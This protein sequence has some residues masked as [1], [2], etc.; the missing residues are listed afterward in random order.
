MSFPLKLCLAS[1]LAATVLASAPPRVSR[2]LATS[3]TKDYSSC[4]VVQAVDLPSVASAVVRSEQNTKSGPALSLEPIC[5][6]CASGT[7][8][9]TDASTCAEPSG[10][11]RVPYNT[12]SYFL[13][14]H[15]ENSCAAHPF[16]RHHYEC[17]DYAHGAIYV[18]GK[19]LSFNV[20][21]STSPCGCVSFA[22]LT[23]PALFSL[24]RCSHVLTPAAALNSARALPQNAALYLVSM[25][26]ATNASACFDKYCDANDVCGERC[27]EIDLM[28]ANA[29]AWVSTVHVPDDGNGEGFGMAHYTIGKDHASHT[30]HCWPNGRRSKN[31]ALHS[32]LRA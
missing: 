24:S 32:P 12:R 7:H 6:A 27:A 26:Q 20:D 29:A 2:Q 19:T 28:E 10:A 9:S 31:T 17:V 14:E 13:S 4:G 1:C 22:S 5:S 3:A 16:Q 21:L 30:L 8:S 18:A 25:P 11:L 15:D 23:L